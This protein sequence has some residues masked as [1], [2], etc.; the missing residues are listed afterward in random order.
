MFDKVLNTPL[1]LLT[2]EAYLGI[3]EKSM[4]ELFTS[5]LI[6]TSYK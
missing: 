3:C 1:Y 6:Y 5:S 4:M 2:P